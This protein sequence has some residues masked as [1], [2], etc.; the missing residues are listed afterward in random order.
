V[1]FA[2]PDL[3]GFAVW[4]LDDL[5]LVSLLQKDRVSILDELSNA[6]YFVDDRLERIDYI[7]DRIENLD[8]D[9]DAVDDGDR[10]P[11][12]GRSFSDLR[13]AAR[14]QLQREI[15]H[16]ANDRPPGIKQ[17]LDKIPDLCYRAFNI[18]NSL[19]KPKVFFEALDRLDLCLKRIK[20]V[21]AGV[22]RACEMLNDLLTEIEQLLQDRKLLEQE[23]EKLI[24][25]QASDEPI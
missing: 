8:N 5:P 16:Q 11:D 2:N 23:L 15:L 24:Q 25:P 6:R 13:R 10:K 14:L 4:Q 1:Q 18:N 17:T 3:D 22:E 7:P 9:D 19:L 21:D 20:Q 12:P